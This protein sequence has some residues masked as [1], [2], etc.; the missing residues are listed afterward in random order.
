MTSLARPIVGAS[1]CTV[2]LLAGCA[3]E[4]SDTA[5]ETPLATLNDSDA[6]TTSTG[7]VVPEWPVTTADVPAVDPNAEPRGVPDLDEV[8]MGDPQAVAQT[9]VKLLL[10]SD[11]RTDTSP[12]TAAERAAPL[13]SDPDRITDLPDDADAAPWWRKLAA[14]GGHTTVETK[15]LD[16]LELPDDAY[17][18]VPIQTTTTYRD[19]S[20]DPTTAVIDVVL[21]DIDGQWRVD[22]TQTRTN[23]G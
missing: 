21:V 17:R 14:T 11:T 3:D 13:L 7:P 8:D 4:S 2:L 20:I 23:E 10:T 16:E 18:M 15:S 12:V 1:L 19:T 22:T 9:Y 6:A 5:A